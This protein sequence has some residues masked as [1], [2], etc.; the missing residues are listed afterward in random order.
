M[1][2]WSFR[3]LC[4]LDK[5]ETQARYRCFTFVKPLLLATF[6]LF[7]DVTD[8]VSQHELLEK[9]FLY[10]T[11]I[12]SR[13]VDLPSRCCAL[14]RRL[15]QKLASPIESR[16]VKPLNTMC[17]LIKKRSETAGHVKKTWLVRV[18]PYAYMC[19]LSC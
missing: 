10:Q 12:W 17:M 1:W 13:F 2:M 18:F 16:L 11:N 4:P 19:A 6:V 3:G 8:T 5:R 15:I 14:Y 7:N 9:R